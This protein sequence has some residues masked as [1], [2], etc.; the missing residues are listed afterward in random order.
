MAYLIFGLCIFLGVH[1]LRIVANGWRNRMRALVGESVWRAGFGAL[2]VLGLLLIVWGYS[3]A[4]QNPVQL[5][6]PPVAMRHLSALFT[7][8][9]FVL[10]AAAYVPANHIKARLRH[11]MVAAVKLWAFAHLL[12]NGNANQMV[13]FGSFLVW[14]ILSFRAA[15]QR[16]RLEKAPPLSAK[17][18][19]TVITVALG[20]ALWLTFTLWLHGLLIGVRPLG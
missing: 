4:R 7:L 15:R 20:A 16:D 8:L 1:S 5:W 12:A 11:P 14:S 9:A 19:A 3:L 6:A 18:G 2:S 17:R 10:V 13:L